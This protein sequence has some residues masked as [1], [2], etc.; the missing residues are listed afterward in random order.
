MLIPKLIDDTEKVNTSIEGLKYDKG[1]ADRVQ[2]FTLTEKALLLGS[3]KKAMSAVLP[4]R[5]ASP[6]SSSMCTR[7]CCS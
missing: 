2:A 5:M 6:R 3:G 7:R 4:R 1:F